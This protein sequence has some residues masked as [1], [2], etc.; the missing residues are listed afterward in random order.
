[1][2]NPES[3]LFEVGTPKAQDHF[4]ADNSPSGVIR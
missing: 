3:M 4:P 2:S 1:M